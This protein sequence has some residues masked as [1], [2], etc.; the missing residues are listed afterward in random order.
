VTFAAPALFSGY[1]EY[2]VALAACWGLALVAALRGGGTARRQATA[3]VATVSLLALV[4]ALRWETLLTMAQ[5][6]RAERNFYGALQVIERDAD[7]PARHRLELTNGGVVHGSQLADPRQRR[8][9][10]VYY[11]ASSGLAAGIAAARESARAAGGHGELRIGCIG[12]GVG[13]IAAYLFPGDT[14][15]IYELNPAVLAVARENFTFLADAPARAEVV[16]GDARLSLERELATTGPR[17][18]DLLVVDAFTGDAIPAHLLTR[19]CLQL[20]AGHLAPDGRLMLHISNRY[21]DLRPLVLG[22]AEDAGRQALIV[23]SIPTDPTEFGATWA[24]IAPGPDA[25]SAAERD[26]ASAS[27]P[28]LAGRTALWTDEYSN[29]FELLQ[30]GD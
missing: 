4:A 6:V 11:G 29:L 25:F 15:R 24:T 18:F 1:W 13:S 30:H 9:P 19:E 16:L 8:K 26:M 21:L 27:R 3:S 28:L 22:L 23:D 17:R 7:D 14:L 10:T 20:Y 12:L 2:H 5:T